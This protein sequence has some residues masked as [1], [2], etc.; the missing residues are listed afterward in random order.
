MVEGKDKP[1]QQD[2]ASTQ[3]ARGPML[4][5]RRL[6]TGAAVGG[7][8]LAGWALWPGDDDTELP[9]AENE[10]SFGIWLKIATSG[11]V[12]LNVPQS[13]MGQG[14][15][16]A[17]AEVA[18]HELGADWRTMAIQPVGAAPGFTNMLLASEWDGA[19]DSGLMSGGDGWAKELPFVVTAGSTSQRMFGPLVREAAAAARAM[20]AMA[21][22]ERWD[23]EWGDL[24]AKDGFIFDPADKSG[25]RR[26]AFADLADAAARESLPEDVPLR[27]DDTSDADDDRVRLDMPSKLDGSANFAADIRLPNMVFASVRSAPVGA[28]L[29]RVEEDAVAKSPGFVGLHRDDKWYAVAANTWWAADKALAAARPVWEAGDA[30]PEDWRI[31]EALVDAIAAKGTRTMSAGDPAAEY[32]D[33]TRRLFIETARVRAAPHAPAETRSA[34]ARITNGAAEIWVATQAPAD[35]RAR[36]A[37]ALGISVDQVTIYPMLAGGSF[38]RNLDNEIAVMAAKVAVSVDRP[39]SLMLSRAEDMRLNHFRPPALGHMKGALDP[40]GRLTALSVKIATPAFMVETME[41]IIGN[42]PRGEARADAAGRIDP[43]A[44]EGA[45]PPYDIANVEVAHFPVDI[46]IRTGRYRGNAHNSGIFFLENFIDM[47]STRVDAE[48]LSWRIGMLANNPRLARCLTRVGEM[49]R[50]NGGM[51]DEDGAAMGLACAQLRG[52]YIA[53]VAAVEPGEGRPVVRKLFAT[54]DAGRIASADIARQQIEGGLLFG[55]ADAI[56]NAVH[57]ERGRLAET[58]LSQIKPLPFADCP[59]VQVEFVGSDEEPGGIGEIGVPAVAPAIAAA[60]ERIDGKRRW[61]L[62]FA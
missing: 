54:V 17:L 28:T 31:E 47:L 53:V 20:L 55:M 59:D 7:G 50:W 13:E 57:F 35:A 56:G 26:L 1:L 46:G 4:T 61:T 42:V 52:S 19:R 22:A 30:M 41:R 15:L 21:A 8:L 40:D 14:V 2:T 34:A 43:L 24:A 58:R 10:R 11:Q 9:A 23:M 60:L 38:G 48:P 32:E 36:V 39:V 3:N 44:V 6:L 51:R 33:K 49:A 25:K 29:A 27:A 45:V 37:L 5:R 62:P 12:T 16:T 18:A